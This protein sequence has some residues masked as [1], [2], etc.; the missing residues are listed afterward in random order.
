MVPLPREPRAAL[1]RFL[2]WAP[3]ATR[4]GLREAASAERLLLAGKTALAAGIAWALA[5]LMPGSLGEYP[6]Y[7]P[8]GALV[9]MYPTVADSLRNGLQSLVGLALGIGVALFVGS[10]ADTAAWSV[11]LVVGVGMIVGGLPRMG[12]GREWVPLAALFVLVAGANRRD[13]FSLAYLV[14]M[15]LGVAVGLAVNWIVFPPLRV[16]AVTPAFARLRHALGDQLEDMAAA[17]TEDEWPPSRKEWATREGLLA[18]TAAEVR[19][20]VEEAEVS[21]RANPRRKRHHRDLAADL[22]DLQALERATFRVQDITDVLT[23]VIWEEHAG[24]RVPAELTPEVAAALLAT[25][26]A[27]RGWGEEDAPEGLLDRAQEA[28]EALSGSYHEVAAREA[29]GDATGAISLALSRIVRMVRDRLDSREPEPGA[30][31]PGLT[32]GPA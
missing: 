1:H 11:A 6:Y 13:V 23:S 7:A 20:A 32:P 18:T 8:L 30:P 3:S 2:V 4:S 26:E 31:G 29:P 15:G 24:T 22:A 16:A 14:Q 10:F 17:V 25:A 27:L 9:S 12:S 19:G 5:Q 21:A 28:I